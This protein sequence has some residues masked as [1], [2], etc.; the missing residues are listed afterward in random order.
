MRKNYKKMSFEELLAYSK[1][2][3]V[4]YVARVL[5]EYV[6]YEVKINHPKIKKYYGALYP[7]KKEVYI[8]KNQRKREKFKTIMHEFLEVLTDEALFDMD[9]VKDD[10]YVLKHDQIEKIVGKILR[11]YRT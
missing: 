10:I 2:L 1:S 7:N 9:V 3:L 5:D 8:C 6:Y 11:K 4:K